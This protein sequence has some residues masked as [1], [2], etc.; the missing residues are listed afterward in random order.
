M[1][2]VPE[3]GSRTWTI[4]ASDR[5]VIATL[6]SPIDA[7]VEKADPA[8]SRSDRASEQRGASRRIDRAHADPIV[9][10][11]VPG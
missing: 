6:R 2:H 7:A 5:S 1:P 8:T 9:D 3:D 10:V 11:E 4:P